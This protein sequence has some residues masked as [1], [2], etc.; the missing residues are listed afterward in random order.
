MTTPPSSL[1]TS[2]TTAKCAACSGS[3]R[4]TRPVAPPGRSKARSMWTFETYP[5][6]FLHL[7]LINDRFVVQGDLVPVRRHAAA[8]RNRD[9]DML[10]A[11][12]AILT[13]QRG[14]ESHGPHLGLNEAFRFRTEVIADDRSEN[15]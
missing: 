4:S 15:P 7:L 10:P 12:N 8:D 13:Q 2:S 6:G 14:G 11:G 1:R 5:P 3:G 9:S